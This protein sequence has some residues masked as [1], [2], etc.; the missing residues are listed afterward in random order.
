MSGTGMVSPATSP[1]SPMSERE[2]DKL[3]G[4]VLQRLVVPV[5]GPELLTMQEAGEE[6]SLYAIW[7]RDLA[8]DAG[9]A[10]SSSTDSALYDVANELSVMPKYGNP[11]DLAYNIDDVI[12]NPPRRF[13]MR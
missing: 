4:Q 7:A 9:I 11:L 2:W 1:A 12:R 10:L 3:I 5:I 13:P 8:N 6:H